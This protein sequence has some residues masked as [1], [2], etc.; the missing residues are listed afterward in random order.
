MGMTWTTGGG[1]SNVTPRPSYQ[2]AIVNNYLTNST[3]LVPPASYFNQNGRAYADAVTVG[4]NLEVVLD[5][6]LVAIDGTSAS[7]PIFAG[8]VTVLN[9]ARLNA[10]KAPLGFITPL[11]YQ[12]YSDAPA[13]WNDITVGHNKC[14]AYG[15]APVCCETGYTATVGWDPVSGVGS[16]NI[17]ALREYV[18]SL[19]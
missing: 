15:W 16:P 3:S 19:P 4:H 2:N 5:S 13:C 1:F 8:M 14:G 12:T 6:S 9:D 10:G 11:M 18:L 17:A 7:A